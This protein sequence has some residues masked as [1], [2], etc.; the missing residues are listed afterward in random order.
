M[1]GEENNRKHKEIYKHH[2]INITSFYTPS[3]ILHLRWLQ[4]WSHTFWTRQLESVFLL[5]MNL[6]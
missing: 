1:I 4:A 6:C 3:E 5:Q 2:P